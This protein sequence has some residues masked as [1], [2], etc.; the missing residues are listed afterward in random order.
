MLEFLPMV[1]NFK[2]YFYHGLET[3]VMSVT[4]LNWFHSSISLLHIQYEEYVHPS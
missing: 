2:S 1:K 3:W 4:M